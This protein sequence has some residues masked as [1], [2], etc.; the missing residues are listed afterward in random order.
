MRFIQIFVLAVVLGLVPMISTGFA[1]TGK[2]AL[3]NLQKALNDV[4]EGK[5]AKA[6]IEADMNTKK[7]QLDSMK[8]E[9]KT[10]R[11][12]IE[13]DK[14]VLSKE[15]L[16]TKTNEIQNK[17]LELQKKAMEYEQELKQKETASVQKILLAL[18]Q[19]VV[20]LAKQQGYSMVY[21]NSSET[22]LYSSDAVDITL[23]LIKAY[24]SRK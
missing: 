15:A 4:E 19:Q 21:E 1:A 12:A 8:T 7:K 10:I 17:F 24:N 22:V 20:S 2:V 16:Q 9:L 14:M 13:K 5:R 23:E 18:K 6:A 3:V 11:D